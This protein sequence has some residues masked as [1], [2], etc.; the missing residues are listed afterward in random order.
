[1][2]DAEPIT[3]RPQ[4]PFTDT[5]SCTCPARETQSTAILET[6]HFIPKLLQCLFIYPFGT[7]VLHLIQIYHQPDATIF[8]FIILTVCLQ[9]NMF[10]A[11]SRPSSGAQ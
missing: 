1:M 6:L 7:G 5:I 4:M 10:R 2:G 8:Q 3:A 11:F 9:L